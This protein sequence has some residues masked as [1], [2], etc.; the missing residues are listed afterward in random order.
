MSIITNSAT[1]LA[2]ELFRQLSQADAETCS[3]AKRMFDTYEAKDRPAVMR[4][5][6]QML[7]ARPYLLD[8]IISPVLSPADTDLRSLWD[9]VDDGFTLAADIHRS[10]A[11]NYELNFGNTQRELQFALVVAL[12]TKKHP[13]A[14]RAF[15]E[16][17]LYTF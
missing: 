6:M 4:A 8:K 14:A 13:D 12:A 16:S 10:L 17:T 5:V 3:L 2:N 11:A 15:I 7:E 9:Q 1:L